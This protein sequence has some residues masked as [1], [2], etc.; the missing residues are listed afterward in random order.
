MA[1]LKK[2]ESALILRTC[3]KDLRSR[4]G[5]QFVRAD[6]EIVVPA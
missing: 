2:A 4:D 6:A 1:K 5:F 3:D